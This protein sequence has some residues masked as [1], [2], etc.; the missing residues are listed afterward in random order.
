MLVEHEDDLT[1]TPEYPS[2]ISAT[3][4]FLC[5]L[6]ILGISLFSA[7]PDHEVAFTLTVQ[8]FQLAPVS[9]T[10]KTTVIAT[11]KGHAPATPATGMITFYNGATYTQIIPM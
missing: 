8:G 5:L 2:F 4:A 10:L 3:V 11:G 6:A 7:A 1:R 9:K